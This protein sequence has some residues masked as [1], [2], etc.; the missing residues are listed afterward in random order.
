MARSPKDGTPL[1]NVGLRLTD[2]EIQQV[3]ALAGSR[4]VTRAEMLRR[5]VQRVLAAYVDA[6]PIGLARP[7]TRFTPTAKR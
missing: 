7:P 3:D 6:Q 1:R 4:A 2:E 5:I